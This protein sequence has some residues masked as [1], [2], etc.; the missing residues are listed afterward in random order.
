MTSKGSVY[1]V[2]DDRHITSMFFERGYMIE[3]RLQEAQIICFIGG[4]DISPQLYGQ[5]IN[6]E[7]HVNVDDRDDIRDIEAW[8]KSTHDQLKVGICRGGQFLNA[9]SGG[10]LYQHVSGHTNT[11]KVHDVIWGKEVSVSSSHHQM[12]I[13]GSTG[14]VLAYA[15]GI[16]SNFMTDKTKIETPGVEPEVVWYQNTKSLCYQGHPEWT[17]PREGSDYFFDLLE[18]VRQ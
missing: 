10:K 11:H 15:E 3:R 7:A 6:P 4:W 5:K 18:L 9:M 13:P 1:I 14:E 16:G 12:M 8:K 2:G 17:P